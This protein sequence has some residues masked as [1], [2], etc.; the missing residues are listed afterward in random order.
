V[1]RIGLVDADITRLDVDAIALHGELDDAR[2]EPRA[3]SPQARE[4]GA[5][6]PLVA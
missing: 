4:H 2:V 3:G 5:A 6:P 1:A